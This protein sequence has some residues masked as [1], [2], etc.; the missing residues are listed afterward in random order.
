MIKVKRRI[1]VEM[2]AMSAAKYHLVYFNRPSSSQV[3]H[4]S[5]DR[6]RP[7]VQKRMQD[8][9]MNLQDTSG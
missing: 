1:Q 6:Q 4:S 7:R 9:C 5:A 2:R 8:P 3:P